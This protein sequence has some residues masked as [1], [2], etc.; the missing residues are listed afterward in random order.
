MARDRGV[1]GLA[2]DVADRA[3]RAW[4]PGGRRDVAI[5]R[6]ATV[7]NMSDDPAHSRREI[8]GLLHANSMGRLVP[9]ADTEPKEPPKTSAIFRHVPCNR[10]IQA[11]W[12]N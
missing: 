8:R 2:H 10:Q 4:T 6:D 7:R 3:V 1:A 5:G 9:L 12:C 11:R